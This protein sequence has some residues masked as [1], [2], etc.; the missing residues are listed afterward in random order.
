M[1]VLATFRA[2]VRAAFPRIDYYATYYGKVVKWDRAAQTVD[3]TTTSKM[4]PSMAGIPFRHGLPGALVDVATGTSVEITWLN[5]DPSQPRAA[6]WSGGE[7]VLKLT[8][9]ADQIILGGDGSEPA[10]KGQTLQGYLN[11][12][13][14]ALSKHA[15]PVSGAV[16]GP[17]I[18]EGTDLKLDTI[19]PPTLTATNVYVK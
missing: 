19:K 6:L 11:S 4:I 8:L 14:L 3:V 13:A 2:L 5:G 9:T 1:D 7:R 17:A 16:A 12:L 15:H 10:A 18:A